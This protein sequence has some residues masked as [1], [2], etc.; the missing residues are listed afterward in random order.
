[1]QGTVVGRKLNLSLLSQPKSSFLHFI[2]RAFCNSTLSR[3]LSH[4][5]R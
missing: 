5:L 1:M 2:L 3:H 4:Y